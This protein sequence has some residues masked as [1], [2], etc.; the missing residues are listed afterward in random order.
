MKHFVI[1]TSFIFFSCRIIAQSVAINNDASQP[2]SSALLDIKSTT[3]GLLIP[4]MTQVQMLALANPQTGLLV[5]QTD[6]TNPGFYFNAGT[7][8]ASVW[9]KVGDVSYPSNFAFETSFYSPGSS[10]F[11]VPANN[12]HKIFFEAVSGGGGAGGT[13]TGNPDSSRGGGGGGGGGFAKGYITGLNSGNNL[14]IIV[15][16]PGGSGANNSSAGSNGSQGGN[17]YIIMGTDTLVNISGGKAGNGATS[18]ATGNY[19]NGGSLVSADYNKVSFLTKLGGVSGS[20]GFIGIPTANL[21][22]WSGCVPNNGDF[23]YNFRLGISLNNSASYTII[24]YYGL[25]AG[26]GTSGQG[27]YVILYW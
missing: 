11:T 25:G 19:G 6:G 24:P 1:L 16:G 5:Y 8:S 9:E 26:S 21:T 4:R 2:D 18:I 17:T 23:N 14:T 7:T 13:Y 15:G 10:P 12:I 27:G 3:K 20:A 22:G